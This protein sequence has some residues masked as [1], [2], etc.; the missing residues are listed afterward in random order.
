MELHRGGTA[1][2]GATPS[3]VIRTDLST[4]PGVGHQALAEDASQAVGPHAARD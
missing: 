2:N 3:G 1:T 4:I